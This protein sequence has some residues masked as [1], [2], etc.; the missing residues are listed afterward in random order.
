VSGQRRDLASNF[1]LVGYGSH[2]Y[3][4]PS[5]APAT[6]TMASTALAIKFIEASI[7]FNVPEIRRNQVL[8][9]GVR[10]L[11]EKIIEILAARS[12]DCTVWLNLEVT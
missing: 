11:L 8:G 5:S 1:F 6:P 3:G 4:R 2:L 7:L 10:P 12:H 9:R